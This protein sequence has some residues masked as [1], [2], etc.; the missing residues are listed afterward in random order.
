MGTLAR[1]WLM[2]AEK[3]NIFSIVCTFPE[4][5]LFSQGCKLFWFKNSI[6]HII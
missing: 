2:P 5:M 4:K 1:N 3:L 6:F